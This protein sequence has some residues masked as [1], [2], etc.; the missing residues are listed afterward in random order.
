MILEIRNVSKRFGELQALHDVSFEVQDGELF[1]L[2]GPNGSGKSTLFNIITGVFPCEGDILF[3]G[4]N[5]NG[6]PT[7]RICY[8]GIGRTFQI[9]QVFT[10]LSIYDNV[11]VGARFGKRVHHSAESKFVR[12]MIHFVDLD[13]KRDHT[14]GALRLYDIKLTMLAAI[15]ATRPKLLLIDEPLA[16]LTP[17]EI[18]CSVDLIKKINSEL[19]ITVIIIEHLMNELVGLCRR[20]MIL[21]YGINIAIGQSQ[22]IIQDPKVIEVY[23][24]REYAASG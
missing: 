3:E 10:S 15:L 1:G 8:Q 22:K 5:I 7:H 4:V 19:H 17:R 18:H 21:N 24:G 14:V 6:L 2:A 20:L 9:P 23:L 12:D 11:R 16:G 13:E